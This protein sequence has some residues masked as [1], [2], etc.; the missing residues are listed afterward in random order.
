MKL[1]LIGSALAGVPPII[2]VTL[3]EVFPPEGRLALPTVN[4]ERLRLLEETAK[5]TFPVTVAPLTEA[6][7]VR[8]AAP[9]AVREAGAITTCATPE[10]SVNAVLGVKVARFA[11]LKENV[12]SLLVTAAPDPSLTVA[13]AENELPTLSEVEGAPVE[14]TTATTTVGDVVGVLPPP[15]LPEPPLFVGGVVVPVL[16]ALPP[17]PPQAANSTANSA[18]TSNLIN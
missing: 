3:R 13:L 6:L 10:E 4:A 15:S 12:T 14:L 2:A 5:S 8:V 1:T 16:P 7:A 18:L 9:V 11:L 17:P